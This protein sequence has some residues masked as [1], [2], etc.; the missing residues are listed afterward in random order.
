MYGGPPE[1]RLSDA[2]NTNRSLALA[3]G[4]VI[5]MAGGRSGVGS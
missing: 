1:K 3:E 4:K 5:E 2:G